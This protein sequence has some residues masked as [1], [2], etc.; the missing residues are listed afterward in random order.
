MFDAFKHIYMHIQPKLLPNHSVAIYAIIEC[1]NNLYSY[2]DTKD[3]TAMI[4]K[5]L[6][7]TFIRFQHL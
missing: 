5:Y 1:H 7:E 4:E 2:V 3:K 6:C